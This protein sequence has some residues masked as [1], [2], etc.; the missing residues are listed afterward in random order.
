MTDNELSQ[1]HVEWYMGK[2]RRTVELML[3]I[4]EESLIDHMEHG[5]KHGRELE[6]ERWKCHLVN[7]EEK[8]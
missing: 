8:R 4:M 3:C 6:A 7:T 2:I 1:A 5:I